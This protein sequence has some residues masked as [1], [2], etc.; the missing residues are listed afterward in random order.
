MNGA[1]GDRRWFLTDAYGRRWCLSLPTIPAPAGLGATRPAAGLRGLIDDA[2]AP[3]GTASPHV[4]S[5]LLAICEALG[6]RR[7]VREH[8]D[9][10]RGDTG[11]RARLDR[12]RTLLVSAAETG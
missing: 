5:S 10:R 9:Q 6:D 7:L 12:V 8:L 4:A 11:W 3:W 1:P 2:F